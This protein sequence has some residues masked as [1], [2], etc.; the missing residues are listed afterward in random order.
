MKFGIVLLLALTACRHAPKALVDPEL[1]MYMPPGATVIAGIDLDRLRATPLFA[2]IPEPF[3]DG[4][5]AL[6]GYDGKALVTASRTGSRVSVSGGAVKGNP[7]DLLRHASDAP[8]WIVARGSSTLPLT[9]NLSN[10]NRLLHQTQ[11]TMVTARVGERVDLE[12]TG[13]CV[14]PEVAQHLEEN[15]RAIA[16]LMKFPLQVRREGTVI[17]ATGSISIEAAGSLF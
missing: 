15:V 5:Y 11:Y 4:S 6:V 9:G 13:V 7:P 3:R 1:A 8:I 2:K 14:S 10:L 12:M 16:T 17:H